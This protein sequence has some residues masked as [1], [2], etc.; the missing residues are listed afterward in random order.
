M[1]SQVIKNR[2]LLGRL[3]DFAEEFSMQHL[4]ESKIFENFVNYVIFSR[5]DPEAFSDP[6]TFKVVD[7]D[8]GGTFGVDAFGLIVNNTLMTTAD[9]LEL[10][11]KSKRIDARLVF[12]QTKRSTSFDSGEFLKFTKAVKDIF[13]EEG[14]IQES[15]DIAETR[16]LISELYK[17]ENSRFFG[18][19]RP[20]CELY[21]ITTGK[22]TGDELSKNLID[23]EIKSI[24]SSVDEVQD[25]KITHINADNLIDFYAEIEN[26]Y[27]VNIAFDKNVPCEKISDVIQAFIG[28]LPVHE[29]LK[30][31]TGTDGGIRKNIFYENVRDFQGEENSV[32]TEISET[33][34]STDMLDKFILLNNGV[35]IVAKNFSNLQATDYRISD[36]YIVNGCQT[37]NMIFSYK[38]SFSTNSPLSIPVKIIHTNSNDLISKV[39]RSTNRQTPVPVEAFAS[40][41][42]FHKRLQDY[43][44]AFSASS[45]EPLF[46]ERRSKEFSNAEQKI[47]RPRVVNLHGQIRSFTAVVLGEPHLILTRNP[48]TILRDLGQKKQIFQED[49]VNAPY[50][51]SSL[52]L[53][54]YFKLQ[55]QG[56]ISQKYEISRYWVCWIV[57][58]L[59]TK[60]I[61]IG[62]LNSQKTESELEKIIDSFKN[63]ETLDST[64][65]KA[66][67]IFES[68]KESYSSSN[69]RKR[70]GELVKIRDFK[71]EVE[72]IMARELQGNK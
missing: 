34:A 9:D 12:I 38:D 36:Y 1:S 43:Y 45:P 68:A 66:C 10:Q 2:I 25:V 64:F 27:D 24:L 29:F 31:I 70:N 55:A 58:M 49:H 17:P 37:S 46:Y 18:N 65:K 23:S 53:F 48:V 47:E 30:L 40:L 7:I 6:S 51:F 20:K 21:F 11:A 42:K 39:I 33:L 61:T 54:L 5:I 14:V 19:T 60:K 28:Y 32:N 63:E 62:N 13:N 4:E 22:E 71:K 44:K 57:R 59:M 8:S 15:E 69:G 3:H 50:Y 35:T 67:S 41:E 52:L 16:E 72:N 56:K 26:K